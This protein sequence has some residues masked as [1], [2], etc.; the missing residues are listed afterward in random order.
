MCSH[1]V[2]A[3]G[4]DGQ[5]QHQ[6]LKHRTSTASPSAK[7]TPP[8]HPLLL[9]ERAVASVGEVER[10]AVEA[11]VGAGAQ[12]LEEAAIWWGA[13]GRGDSGQ[14]AGSAV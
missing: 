14:G 2:P 1:H 3:D 11:G 13:E 10:A 12:Q 7:P 6:H 8:S 4:G 9:A 5:L